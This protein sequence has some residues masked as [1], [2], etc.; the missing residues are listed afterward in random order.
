LKEIT[1]I[2]GKGGTGKTSITGAI[3]SIAKSAVFCDND[4]DAANLHLVL[5]PEIKQKHVFYG[6]YVAKIN[7]ESCTQCGLCETHC[8]FD[9]IDLNDSGNYVINPYQCEGCRLCERICPEEAITSE[10]SDNN[11][12]YISD[13]LYGPLVHA[14]MGPGEENS[15]KLVTELRKQA[16][17]I[18]RDQQ[19][20]F[21]INDGPPGIGCAAI[22]SVTGTDMVVIVTE[23]TKSGY[24]D[25]IR[26][27]DLV[28]SFK[29]PACAIINKHDLHND[30]TEEIVQYLSH[31]NIP[32][33]AKLP[34]EEKMVEAAIQGEPIN[35]LF[36][37][38]DPAKTIATVWNQIKSSFTTDN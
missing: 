34:F 7:L 22:S 16:R 23:P 18:A 5:S 30:L 10:R 29:I 21:I 31:H 33:L 4:V 6:A 3:A 27:I 15:G 11:Q 13:T 9:A 20:E 19:K 24:H 32:L 26:V 28:K 36:P 12:W 37:E 25:L 8:R 2:S 35:S 14:R 17:A 38:C 1:I